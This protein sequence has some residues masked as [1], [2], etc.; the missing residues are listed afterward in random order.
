ME[1]WTRAVD[2]VHGKDLIEADHAG[3]V[4]SS[5]GDVLRWTQDI[6]PCTVF[7]DAT[8][9][10]VVVHGDFGPNNALL[11][12]Y[13]MTV[14]ALVD[15]EWAHPGSPIEDVAWCEWIV[16]TFDPQ[17][18]DALPSFFTAYGYQPPWA[19]R[20]AAMAAKCR[21]LLDFAIAKDTHSPTVDVRRRQLV[22]IEGWDE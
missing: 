1:L 13:D 11:D 20:Q 8:P 7:T 4:L 15:W 16:R 12:P 5:C 19:I 3:A 6:E 9:S 17:H 22:S 18:M 21:Q 2:G 10:Q 14:T